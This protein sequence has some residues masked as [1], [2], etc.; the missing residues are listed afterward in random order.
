[1]LTVFYYIKQKTYSKISGTLSVVVTNKAVFDIPLR[2]GSKFHGAKLHECIKLDE[3]KFARGHKI[4]RRDKIA[5]RI[6]CTEGQTCTSYNFARLSVLHRESSLHG[7][8]FAQNN[9]NQ[10]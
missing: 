8:N 1:M 3:D 9:T 10:K 5:R 6:F 7:D 2:A 4:K